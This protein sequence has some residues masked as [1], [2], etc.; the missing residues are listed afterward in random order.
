MKDFASTISESVTQLGQAFLVAYYLPASVF[1]LVHLYIL[2]PVWAGTAPGFL[3]TAGEV[4]LPLIGDA[5]LASLIGTLLLPLVVGIVLVGLNGVLIVAFEGRPWW[6]RYGLLYPLA[7]FNRKRCQARYGNL[8]ALRAEYRR[9][10]SLLLRASP[11]GEA[12]SPP[13]A[14]LQQQL[15]GLAVQIDEEQRAVEAKYPLQTVPHELRRVCPTTFGNAYAIA[16]EYAFERYGADSVLFWPRLREL[17]YEAAEGHS[18]RIT[19]QKTSL[20]L[21]LNFAFICGLLALE[22]MLTLRFGPSGHD[23]LLLLLALLGGVLYA[24]YY[25]GSVG[26]VHGLGELI[27]NSFDYHRG[28]VLEAFGLEK[29][30]DLLAEQVVWIRLATF[31]RRGEPFY[32]PADAREGAGAEEAGTEAAGEPP[33]PPPT[34]GLR[35]WLSALYRRLGWG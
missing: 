32:F 10:S 7:R 24:S 11:A 28:L 33:A 8:D 26:A 25:R 20:D 19:Q 16:E 12:G 35:R 29:P 13:L 31:I 30:E 21:S 2:I 34:P 6:L 18:E 9:V 1:V 3:A 5:D 14:S 22:A 17:M 4:A 23:G 15:A 27:K